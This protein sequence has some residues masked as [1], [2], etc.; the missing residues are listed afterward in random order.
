MNHFASKQE[1]LGFSE[2]TVIFFREAVLSRSMSLTDDEVAKTD[3]LLYTPGPIYKL[4][5]IYRMV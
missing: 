5:S 1:S 3:V 4:Q 2:W